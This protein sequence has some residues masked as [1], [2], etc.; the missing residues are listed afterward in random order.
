VR[1]QPPAGFLESRSQLRILDDRERTIQ[2][3]E[4]VGLAR[5]HEGDRTLGHFR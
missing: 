5:C 3:V 4:V 1:N 2:S